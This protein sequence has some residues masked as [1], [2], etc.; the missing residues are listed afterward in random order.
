MDVTTGGASAGTDETSVNAGVRYRLSGAGAAVLVGHIN[1]AQNL[2]AVVSD[3]A[4][5]N[6]KAIPRSEF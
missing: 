4:N 2:V 5:E 1:V 3:D 6:W